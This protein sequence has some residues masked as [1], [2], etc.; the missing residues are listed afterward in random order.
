MASKLKL[1]CLQGVDIRELYGL[2]STPDP[3]NDKELKALLQRQLQCKVRHYHASGDTERHRD[4]NNAQRYLDEVGLRGWPRLPDNKRKQH[5]SEISSL[6]CGT[7]ATQNIQ[8]HIQRRKA[9]DSDILSGGA[10]I[11]TC[12]CGQQFETPR[13]FIE[14]GQSC[15][16]VPSSARLRQIKASS[17]TCIYECGSKPKNL[18]RH[19]H[20]QHSEC[21]I[22]LKVIIKDQN[23]CHGLYARINPADYFTKEPAH[24]TTD[25]G[26]LISNAIGGLPK[27]AAQALEKLDD[28]ELGRILR[29][30]LERRL[31]IG[32][33]LC[34]LQ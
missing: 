31:A 3:S 22:C 9:S 10:K 7:N 8:T 1:Y 25:P 11:L 4:I 34:F 27:C 13:K 16:D 32:T 30:G 20:L 23:Q 19:E 29:K 2:S 14:H 6:D 24:R 15:A 21:G 5:A 17:K 26:V 33:S 18:K 28:G 12:L